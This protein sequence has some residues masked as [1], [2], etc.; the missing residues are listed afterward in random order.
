MDYLEGSQLFRKNYLKDLCLSGYTTWMDGLPVG[1]AAFPEEL[2]EGPLPIWI[3]CLGGWITWRDR[4]LS[5]SIASR[6][7]AYLDKLSG[8]MD[9]L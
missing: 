3:N 6:T 9:Y 5:G 2:P 7:S 1:I 8:W 4:S